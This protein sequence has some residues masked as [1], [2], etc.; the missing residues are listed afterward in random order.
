MSLWLGVMI[1]GECDY[2]QYYLQI[3]QR[4]ACATFGYFRTLHGF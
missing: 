1:T 2:F 4:A 3:W